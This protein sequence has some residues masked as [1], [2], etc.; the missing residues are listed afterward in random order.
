M[1]RYLRNFRSNGLQNLIIQREYAESMVECGEYESSV[2]EALSEG[3]L[4][5][6]SGKIY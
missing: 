4:S 1:M 2:E 3:L 5:E 6:D